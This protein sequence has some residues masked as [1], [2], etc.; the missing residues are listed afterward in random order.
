M[1]SN[2][3]WVTLNH[4]QQTHYQNCHCW[5]NTEGRGHDSWRDKW[6]LQGQS[7]ANEKQGFLCDN[8]SYKMSSNF[9]GMTSFMLAWVPPTMSKCHT[10]RQQRLTLLIADSKTLS[11]TSALRWFATRTSDYYYSIWSWYEKCMTGSSC[12]SKRVTYV[13]GSL[14]AGEINEKAY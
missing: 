6:P 13:N 9:Q 4:W 11:N 5:E 2:S 7:G 12:L 10:S 8:Q 1:R 3:G 14:S